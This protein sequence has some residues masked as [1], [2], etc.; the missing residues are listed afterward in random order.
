MQHV[1]RASCLAVAIVLNQE[2]HYLLADS[3]RGLIP[4]S[5]PIGAT[6]KQAAE[7][8]FNFDGYNQ[9]A[10]LSFEIREQQ[11]IPD[12]TEWFTTRKDRF[13]SMKPDFVK[14][15]RH[16]TD[17][18]DAIIRKARERFRGFNTLTFRPEGGQLT[19]YLFDVVEFQFPDADS[20]RIEKFAW[21]SRKS[22]APWR[23][24]TSKELE[25]LKTRD[26]W[27]INRLA[28]ALLNPRAKFLG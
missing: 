12:L 26:G 9:T 3:P 14:Y 17:L 7:V 18:D 13:T 1:N 24:V 8:L 4:I 15:L 16:N 28:G 23:F 2:G 6:R 25:K 27:K 21:Q 19:F 10:A 11:L 20:Q 22:G 5:A